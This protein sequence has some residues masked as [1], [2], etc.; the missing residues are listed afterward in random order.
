MFTNILVPTDG[1]ALSQRAEKYAVQL[2]RE[3]GGRL[4]A[5]HVIPSFFP[6][7]YLDGASAYPQLYSRDDYKRGTEAAAKRMLD[8]VARQAA[9]AKVPCD[10]VYKTGDAAWKVIIATAKSKR[11]DLI[12][13]ASHGRRGIEAVLLGSEATKVLTHSKTPVLVYR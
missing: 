9:Q 13:M 3:T 1:S 5:L 4:T 7:D 10:L 8:R 12:V 2:A 6:T 11:C